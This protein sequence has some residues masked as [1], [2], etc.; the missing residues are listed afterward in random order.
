[1]QKSLM[2]SS[3]LKDLFCMKAL[4][5]TP[6]NQFRFVLEKEGLRAICMPGTSLDVSAVQE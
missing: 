1:M 5:N 4:W 2:Q 6:E 3:Y